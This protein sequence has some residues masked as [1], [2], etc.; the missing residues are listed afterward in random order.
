MRESSCRGLLISTFL[1]AWMIGLQAVAAESL[2]A[3]ELL[4]VN[5]HQGTVGTKMTLLGS[6]FGAKKGK[7]LIG[8]A[9][10]KILEWTDGSIQCQLANVTKGVSPGAYDVTIRPQAKGAPPL[11]IMNGFTLKGPEIDSVEPASGLAGDE[12]TVHGLFFGIKKGKVTLGGKTCKVF[13]WTMDWTTGESQIRFAIPKGLASEINELKVSNAVGSDSVSFGGAYS[14]TYCF[15]LERAN[16][17]MATE[18]ELSQSNGTVTAT[19]SDLAN[20]AVTGPLEGN[21]LTLTGEIPGAGDLNMVLTFSG[22]GQTL[23]GDYAVGPEQGTMT[24]SRGHCANYTYPEGNPVCTLPVQN[25]SLVTGGQQYNSVH[26]GTTHTGLDFKLG[27]TLSNI[28]APCDGVIR[29]IKRH[30]ISEGNIIFDVDIRYNGGWGTFIAFEP[31]SPDPA[32]AD[33]QE[34]QILVSIN[35]VVHRGDLLGRLIVPGGTAYPHVHW[36]VY[37]N[38]AGRT[39]VCPRNY[40]LPHAQTQLDTLYGGFSGPSGGNLLPACLP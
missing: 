33:L 9:A 4:Q 22:D 29:E 16:S 25:L 40:L 20:V 5:P 2:A 27:T 35:Q 32:I 28:I 10:L 26:D 31:Y 34:D 37:R 15:I 23:S 11:V 39:P 12:I 21:T 14:G 13:S 6:G 19:L 1:L 8:S 17:V 38:E 24:G 18:V 3:G 30:A 7:A 36:G